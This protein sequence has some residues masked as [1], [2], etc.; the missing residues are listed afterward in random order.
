[1]DDSMKIQFK[2]VFE[3]KWNN[4]TCNYKAKRG[5][6]IINKSLYF[7]I[8]ASD[9][10]HFQHWQRISHSAQSDIISQFEDGSYQRLTSI[11]CYRDPWRNRIRGTREAQ[12]QVLICA[13]EGRVCPQYGCMGRRCCGKLG[14]HRGLRGLLRALKCLIN[15][16]TTWN[17]FVS[18]ELC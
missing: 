15:C 11:L 18:C 2:H 4:T 17:C 8:I 3:W 5:L 1:M 13:Q 9:L 7:T 10:A 14:R 12:E 6:A 16:H